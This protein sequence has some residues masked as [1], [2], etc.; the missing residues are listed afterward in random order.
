M[1][2][3]VCVNDCMRFPTLSTPHEVR[4]AVNQ[5]CTVCKQRRYEVKSTSSGTRIIPRKAFYWFGVAATIRDRM[6]TDPSF[7]KHRTTGREEYFY[8]SEEAKRLAEKAGMNIWHWMVSCYEVGVDWAQ[9]FSS[10]VHSTG[11]IMLRCADMPLSHLNRRR[12][13]HIVG[14]I[15][16]PAEPSNIDPYLEPLLE[17]FNKY[18]PKSECLFGDMPTFCTCA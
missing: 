5:C 18:G 8:P 17:E 7:C 14:I 13:T 9:M 4:A 6:F 12:F 10:K 3:D 15:P 16:G 1:Q 2:V 11:F